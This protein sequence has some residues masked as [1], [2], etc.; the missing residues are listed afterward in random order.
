M[1]AL[2]PWL[3]KALDSF[4][5]P[6]Q[7]KRRQEFSDKFFASSGSFHTGRPMSIA[8]L[9][10]NSSACNKGRRELVSCGAALADAQN[11]PLSVLSTNSKDT[12]FYQK[13]GFV[14]LRA[15]T[16][17]AENPAWKE[18]PVSIDVMIRT[19]KHS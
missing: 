17:G 11:C 2:Y 13:M 1:D 19:I 8:A 16:L 14:V 15:I 10:A 3:S 9:V 18:S 4:A 5:T 12:G 7:R 6:E